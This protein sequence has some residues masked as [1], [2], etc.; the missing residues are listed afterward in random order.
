MLQQVPIFISHG[1]PPALAKAFSRSRCGRIFS[2]FSRVMRVGLSPGRCARWPQSGLSGPIFSGP[3]DCADLVNSLQAS[4]IAMFFR[5]RP[6]HFDAGGVRRDGTEIE[7]SP[8]LVT[9]HQARCPVCLAEA[10]VRCRAPE[11]PGRGRSGLMLVQRHVRW[12]HDRVTVWS[13]AVQH[14][15]PEAVV[16]PGQ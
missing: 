9:A 13:A 15:F 2:L 4:G 12:L 1:P 16:E 6:A 11:R 7:R 8:V 14:A 3:H 10:V 5:G